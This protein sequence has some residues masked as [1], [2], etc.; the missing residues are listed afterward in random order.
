MCLALPARVVSVGGDH[1][2]LARAECGGV[3]RLVNVGLLAEPVAPGDW[4]LVHLGF[5]LSRVTAEEAEAALDVYR[6]EAA[7]L[8]PHRDPGAGAGG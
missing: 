6:D 8:A 7:A 5:A 4:I 2:D 1:P 3:L